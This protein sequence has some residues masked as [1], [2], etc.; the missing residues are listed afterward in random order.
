MSIYLAIRLCL[1][2]IS[3]VLYVRALM[4]QKSC[5]VGMRNA[6]LGNHLKNIQSH[7]DNH[8]SGAP[9]AQRAAKQSPIPI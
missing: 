1:R 5:T 9:A 4:T 8:N 2:E 6:K 3:Y 7:Q